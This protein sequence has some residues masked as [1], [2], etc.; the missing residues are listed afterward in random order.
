MD[1][2]RIHEY[3]TISRQPIF[4]HVRALTEQQY[5][6][7]F[8]I[9]LGSVGRTLTHI[10]ICEWAYVQRLLGHELPPYEAW[11]IQD[12]KPPP[13]VDLERTWTPQAQQ[14]REVIAAVRDWNEEIQYIVTW[15][16]PPAR[17]TAT[18]G[19]IVTQ[20]VL[21]EIHHRAQVL[22]ML[23]LL[24]SACGDIDYNALMFRRE[25]ISDA[26]R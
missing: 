12:E 24:G 15:R 5:L 14:T 11:P 16:E 9:G 25:D 6:Q 17:V 18:A 26:A 22:N 7:T 8:P 13:F 19:D 21:H 4:D 2:L 10:M 3:L 23:R 1:P 20:L